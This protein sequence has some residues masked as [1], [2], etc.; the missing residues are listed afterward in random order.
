MNI[1]EE[2]ARLRDL[3]PAS[4][5]MYTAIKSKP[6][7]PELISSLA[8]LPWQKGAQININ[9][10]LWRQLPESHR[11][12][13]LLHEISWR[14]KTKWLQT[15]AYQGIAAA[16]AIGGIV[17]AVQGDVTGIA[18]AFLLGTIGINQI[19]RTNKSSQVQVLADNEAIEIAQKRGYTEVEAARAMLDAIPAAAK[20]AGRNTPEFTELIRCQNL[21]AIAG[22][23]KTT[24]PDDTINDV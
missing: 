24:I 18:I 2:I 9:F 5:R 11:D 8:I 7:Q 13:L 19:L 15:G 16:A 10:R 12:M 1:N 22:L 17:E 14:Q 20:L 21:R 3:L 23:S 4:W 6:E